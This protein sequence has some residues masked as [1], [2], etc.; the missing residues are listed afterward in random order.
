MSVYR[1]CSI[2]MAIVFAIVGFIFLLL[3]SDVL[4]FF[5][6]ISDL[7]GIKQSPVDGI[8]F[9]LILAVGYMYL[10]SLLAFLMYKHPDN[11]DFPFLLANAK[12]VSAV[13]STI[14]FIWHHPYLIYITNGIVDGIIGILVLYLYLQLKKR[15]S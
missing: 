14:F 7:L 13:L 2:I 5:N 1:I 9:Y 6:T 8:G 4:I 10:V 3:S 11:A 15:H 12:L